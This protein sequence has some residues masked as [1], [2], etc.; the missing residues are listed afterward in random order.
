MT[1]NENRR[2]GRQSL[3]AGEYHSK[4][5]SKQTICLKLAQRNLPTAGGVRRALKRA[6][7]RSA[8][9]GG[10]SPALATRLLTRLGLVSA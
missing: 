5:F 9:A 3:H 4:C 6:I 10:L 1:T 8:M 7:V 2:Q